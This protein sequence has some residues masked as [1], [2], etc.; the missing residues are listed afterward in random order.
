MYDEY[1]RQHL[2]LAPKKKAEKEQK[3]H[4]E[5]ECLPQILPHMLLIESLRVQCSL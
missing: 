1:E 4:K 2:H 5:G 3:Q